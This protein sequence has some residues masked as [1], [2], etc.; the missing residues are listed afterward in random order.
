MKSE[1]EFNEK[2]HAGEEHLEPEEV[3][4]FD[5]KMPFDPST[6]VDTLLEYGLSEDDTIVD[7]GAGTGVFSLAIAEYCDRAVAVD[8]SATMLDL[9]HTKL[10]KTGIQN[11]E[12]VN[13]GFLSY[14]HQGDTASYAFSKD[15]LHH[16][17][18]SWK[19]EAL[20]NIGATLEHGGIFRLRDFVFTFEPQESQGKIEDWINENKESTVFT[21]EDICVHFREEYSTYGFLLEPMLERVGF[22]ILEAKYVDDF[23]AEYICQWQGGHE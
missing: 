15:A 16:L 4:Q 7:F 20:K 9:I 1:W 22:E 3:A 14:N 19:I 21:D 2:Q 23:Y 11:V 17:P 6:E 13:D 8:V 10:E 5:E 12:T 18:D